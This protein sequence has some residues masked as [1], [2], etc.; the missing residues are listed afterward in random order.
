MD[1]SIPDGESDDMD[2]SGASR[3][4]NDEGAL[5]GGWTSS[6]PAVLGFDGFSSFVAEPLYARYNTDGPLCRSIILKFLIRL[7]CC[8]AIESPPWFSA[9]T[10]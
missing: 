6:S 7:G 10:V 2:S 1:T 3:N 8:L 9:R 5:V 4:P